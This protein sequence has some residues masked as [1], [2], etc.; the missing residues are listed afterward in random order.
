[1]N[2]LKAV[3]KKH[4]ELI[5]FKLQIQF[6]SYGPTPF[7]LPLPVFSYYDKIGSATHRNVMEIA[8][9]YKSSFQ[10]VITSYND[11]MAYLPLQNVDLA[12]L[13]SVKILVLLC[14]EAE[15]SPCPLTS[16]PE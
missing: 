9:T 10:F 4:G 8:Y 11:S 5:R 14:A 16:L 6:F 7:S 15:Y 3:V 2:C 13:P 1:M 12:N